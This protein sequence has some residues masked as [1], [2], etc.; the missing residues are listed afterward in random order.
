MKR[1]LG[2]GLLIVALVLAFAPS[3]QAQAQSQG[4]IYIVEA[5]DTLWGIAQ[6]FGTDPSALAAAN[7]ILVNSTLD[8]GQQLVIPGFEGVSGKLITHDAAFGESL[9][10]MG[11]RY[12]VG[13][14]TLIR[15]NRIVNPERMYIG[16]SLIVPQDESGAMSLPQ[17]LR[18]TVLAGETDTE[19]AVR[20]NL[21]PWSLR[22]YNARGFRM[23]VVP[24]MVLALP[25]SG[26]PTTAVPDSAGAILVSPLPA[27][28]G[29][30]EVVGVTADSQVSVEGNL[31]D[32]PLHF[33]RADDKTLVALQG[34]YA[35][36]KPGLYDL[37]IRVTPAAAGQAPFAFTQPVYVADGGYPFDPILSVPPETIDPA[38]T[39]PENDQV[40][41]IMAPV[42]P[43]KMW[44]GAFQF[45]TGYTKSF[46]SRF[47]SRRNYNGTGYNYYHSGLDFYGGTGTKI[48]APA[49]GRVVFTGKMTVRGNLT[50]ID[51]GWGV[52]TAY[53]HQS[54]IDVKVGDVVEPGQ[55]IG[56]IG[57]TGRVTGPHL[58]W[59]VWVG[60]VPVN[61]MEWTQQAF[62]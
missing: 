54:E 4:P 19:L 3:W 8:V 61:P 17:S 15:L 6:R 45:P 37:T 18:Q 40:A 16:Q 31:A 62:P 60:G 56:L 48:T 26:T 52:Y 12:G 46:P 10:S 29:R 53:F 39:A 13:S 25:G 41:K 42:T 43:D 35:L 50:I 49:K 51:H 55:P 58:H 21:N 38:V 9:S 28:Q 22:S 24:G 59:E 2:R 20:G 27:V 36:A 33:E 11:L 47:G 7:N 30:T 5:G 14:E 34:V 23:W 44:Q 1:L 57:A 32:N